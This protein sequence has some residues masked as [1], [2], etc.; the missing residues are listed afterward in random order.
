MA[1]LAGIDEA[2]YGPLMGPL[3]ISASAFTL[4][5]ELL[6]EDLYQI[7]KKSI[8]NRRKH[9]AGRLLISDSKKAYS[10]SIGIKHLERTT[11]TA[12][13]CLNQTP[14]SLSGLLDFLCPDSLAR[15]KGYNWYENCDGLDRICN[16]ADIRIACKVFKEDM[17]K[18]NI[19]LQGLQTHCL[20]VAHYNKLVTNTNNKAAV[21][22]SSTCSLIKSIWDNS[23]DPNIQIIIDRQGGR[24]HYRKHLLRMFGYLELA[25]LKESNDNSSYELTGRNKK[26]RLHFVTKADKKYMPVSLSSMLSKYIREILIHK[27]NAYFLKHH[28]ALKPTAGYWKDGLRFISDL[29]EHIPHVKY[30][31]NRLIRC[32]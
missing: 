9:L 11:L 17:G 15:L 4:P 14:E 23:H 16:D 8:A 25:V 31:E 28:Q 1:V 29:K 6:K 32:R 19:A 10:K 18:N 5:D 7:L 20:D 24:T 2:G 12:L 3:V 13:K 27:I 26:M 30:D 21:L 22:F